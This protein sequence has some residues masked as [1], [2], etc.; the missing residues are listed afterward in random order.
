M[1][2]ILVSLHVHRNL[3]MSLF[4]F[5]LQPRL[6]HMEVPR[7]GVKWELQLL[8]YTTAAAIPDPSLICNLC[9]S[10]WQCEVFKPLSQA[11][12]QTHILMILV[13]FLTRWTI[14]G[15]PIEMAV[16]PAFNWFCNLIKN[17][18][19]ISLSHSRLRIWCCHCCGMIP[20]LGTSTCCRCSQ[21]KKKPKNKKNK[22][23]HK[24]HI[25][26]GLFLDSLLCCID[27]CVYPSSCCTVLITIAT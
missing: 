7:L 5:F 25:C 1:D 11:R 3:A 13:R 12:D 21:K 14:I 22:K 23:N 20:G 17:H 27:L 6:W 4:F 8:A 26:I 15:T 24:Q 16:F 2:E 18:L 19:G 10:L 9:C